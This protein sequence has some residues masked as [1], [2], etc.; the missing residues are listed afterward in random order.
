MRIIKMFF[1]PLSFCWH[2]SPRMFLIK[3]IWKIK[4]LSL[5]VPENATFTLMGFRFMIGYHFPSG[6]IASLSSSFQSCF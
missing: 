5:Y 4:L 6:Y 1:F 3:N 2:K